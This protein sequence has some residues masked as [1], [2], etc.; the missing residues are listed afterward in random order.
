MTLPLQNSLAPRLAGLRR[1]KSALAWLV[2]A[3]IALW[4]E[5]ALAT[6]WYIRP[7]G[8]GDAPTIQA[9]VDAAAPGDVILVAAGTYSATSTVNVGG[10]LTVVCVAIGKD[11][12]L[13][14]ESGAAL[15]TIG[16]LNAKVAVYVHDVGS[17]VEVK[18]FRIQTQ[19]QGY[20]CLQSPTQ[21]IGAVPPPS[22]P[23]GIKCVNAGP[24]LWENDISGNGVG[25]ELV[26]AP[27][28][29]TGNAISQAL[30]GVG[31]YSGAN[32]TI[33]TNTIHGCGEGV[34]CE[35]STVS[36]DA[37]DMYDS[38]GALYCIAGSSVVVSNNKIHDMYYISVDCGNSSAQVENNTF[39]NTN[40]AISLGAMTGSSDVRRNIF[41]NQIS[42]A[43]SL[44]DNPNAQI[45]IEGNTVD[46]TTNGA[47]IFCQ[48]GSSPVIQQNIIVRSLVGIRCALSSFP[49]TA[50]NDIMATQNR[51]S[52]ECADQTGMNGN[53]SVDPQFCGIA[54]GGNYFLQA[55]SPCAPGN[56]PG[57]ADCGVIGALNVGCSVV[58]VKSATWGSVKAM[59]RK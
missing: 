17:S 55:D 4:T 31:C 47:A 32:A 16:N 28:V 15:T 50:C 13:L 42:G 58:S 38:C 6:T 59:Y 10:T 27:A 11:V 29:V 1:P 33:S 48:A 39:T 46:L 30:I 34:H 35:S 23:R 37:N 8:T 25:L 51:Y 53:I 2:I 56:H 49:T 54:G 9:G 52:G 20:S 7:D 26:G 12:K 45:T 19:S 3:M 21:Q 44:S 22:I 18:G 24:K 57:G 14:S 43:V 5:S 40:L 41:Y 36:I